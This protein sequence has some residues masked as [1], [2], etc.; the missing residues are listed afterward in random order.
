MRRP[1]TLLYPT[2]FIQVT[3]NNLRREL[4]RIHRLVKRGVVMAPSDALVRGE[5]AIDRE[6]KSYVARI[7]GYLK[8]HNLEPITGEEPD[9]QIP[10]TESKE[11]WAR[12]VNDLFRA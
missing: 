3:T 5:E 10:F 8:R 4:R 7:N 6:F 2:E 9:T 11:L 1:D 12:I